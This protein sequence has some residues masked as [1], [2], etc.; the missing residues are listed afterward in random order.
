[1]NIADHRAGSFCKDISTALI[2]LPQIIPEILFLSEAALTCTR[3][4]LVYHFNGRKTDRVA[5]IVF[6]LHCLP[7]IWKHS[8]INKVFSG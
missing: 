6:I 5:K 4:R 2:Y 3:L 7:F 8:G 1:M